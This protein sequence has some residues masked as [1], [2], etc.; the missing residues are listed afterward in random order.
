MTCRPAM[1]RQLFVKKQWKRSGHEI[2][3]NGIRKPEGRA[4]DSSP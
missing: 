4:S 3:F 2:Q 1:P